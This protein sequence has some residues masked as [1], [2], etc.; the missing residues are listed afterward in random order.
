MLRGM[1]V[2]GLFIEQVVLDGWNIGDVCSVVII[3]KAQVQMLILDHWHSVENGWA[4]A[5]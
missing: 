2:H 3:Y 1:K 5:G 4:G